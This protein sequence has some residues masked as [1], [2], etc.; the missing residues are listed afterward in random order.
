MGFHHF[1]NDE[2]VF[3]HKTVVDSPAFEIGMKFPDERRLHLFRFPLGQTEALIGIG[4]VANPDN[5]SGQCGCGKVDPPFTAFAD[6]PKDV[7]TG[8]NHTPNQGRGKLHDGMPT[9]RH[10]VYLVAR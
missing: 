7:I 1:E 10:D 2:I 4:G 5:L 6:K 3:F 9:H 8:R